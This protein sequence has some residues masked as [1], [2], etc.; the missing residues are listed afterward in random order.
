MHIFQKN[1]ISSGKFTKGGLVT[2]SPTRYFKA[3]AGIILFVAQ[4]SKAQEEA[5]VPDY[6]AIAQS[7]SSPL[8]EQKGLSW[9]QIYTHST[10][11]QDINE[12]YPIGSQL[13]R[14]RY[15]MFASIGVPPGTTYHIY[16]SQTVVTSGHLAGLP[17]YTLVTA[18]S[19]NGD[20]SVIYTARRGEETELYQ[21][22]D[23]SLYQAFDA[24]C[25]FGSAGFEGARQEGNSP[26]LGTN[27]AFLW[28][29]GG[30]G[31]GFLPN[32][33]L[34]EGYLEQRQ[35]LHQSAQKICEGLL[36]QNGNWLPIPVPVPDPNP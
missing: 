5:T 27:I 2:F 32:M 19:P 16:N 20:F 23:G 10:T 15:N 1:M 21:K 24:Q 30:F 12:T 26:S 33:A 11:T 35:N 17:K 13:Q 31:P 34:P 3:L 36:F 7:G 18:R 4:T 14:S 9:N 22:S 29:G 28:E 8:W 25:I 6:I